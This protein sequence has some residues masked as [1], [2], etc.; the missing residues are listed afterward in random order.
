MNRGDGEMRVLLG[1]AV[2]WKVLSS[3]DHSVI[4]QA[5]NERSAHVG[6][7]MRILA[8]RAHADDGIRRVV[9]HVQHRSERDVDADRSAFESR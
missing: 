8:E 7:Q 6:D 9:V 5:V 1:V 4:L 3:R 2:A